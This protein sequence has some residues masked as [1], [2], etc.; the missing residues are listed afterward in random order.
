MK[1]E[2]EKKL[3]DSA[4]RMNNRIEKRRE[5]RVEEPT[6]VNSVTKRIVGYK[7]SVDQRNPGSR[8]ASNTLYRSYSFRSIVT[9]GNLIEH[10]VSCYK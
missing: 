1:K 2:S 8:T 7:S 5:V 3:Y 9:Q 6:S 4:K 10:V